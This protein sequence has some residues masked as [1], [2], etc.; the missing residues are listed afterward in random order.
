MNSI[1]EAEVRNY[2]QRTLR[3]DPYECGAIMFHIRRLAQMSGHDV[4]RRFAHVGLGAGP[5]GRIAAEIVARSMVGCG[6]TATEEK[7]LRIATDRWVRT[8]AHKGR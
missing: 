6:G 1:V 5:E 4:D 3:H 7:H 8:T 2:V